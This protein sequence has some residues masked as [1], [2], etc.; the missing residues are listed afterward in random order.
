MN[1]LITYYETPSE[2]KRAVCLDWLLQRND[3]VIL[4]SLWYNLFS[5]KTMHQILVSYGV[6]FEEFFP[7]KMKIDCYYS[8][9]LSIEGSSLEIDFNKENKKR[10]HRYELETRNDGRFFTTCLNG[11]YSDE[12]E[13]KIDQKEPWRC[14][15]AKAKSKQS[16]LLKAVNVMLRL[17]YAADTL[18]NAILLATTP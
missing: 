3:P 5:A 8:N 2:D 7:G 12:R 4:R 9:S 18:R 16:K 13:L 15:F 17:Q 6:S 14:S 1:P 10:L 11:S